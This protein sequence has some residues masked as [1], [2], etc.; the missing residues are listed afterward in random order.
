M[1]EQT[2]KLA[3]IGLTDEALELL[4]IARE[5]GLFKIA[6]VGDDRVERAEMCARGYE[7]P[8]YTD[9]RQLIVQTDADMLLFGAPVHECGDYIKLGMQEHFHILQT[10]PP[11]LNF[12]QLAAFYHLAKKENVRFFTMPHRR[13]GASFNDIREFLTEDQREANFWHLITAVCHVP[14]GELEPE[15]RW[16]YDPQTAGGG[17][18]LQSCYDMVDQLLL[19]FGMPQRVYALMMSQAPDR[20]QRMSL[21]EDTAVVTMEFTETLIA[22]LCASRTLGPAR[23]HVRIHGK[24][25]HL[26]ATD[27]EAVLYDN[28]GILLRQR[29]YPEDERPS[30]KRM[31]ENIAMGLLE[32]EGNVFYPEHGFDLYTFAVIEAA[33][34]SARTGMAEEPARILKLADIDAAG[35]I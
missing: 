20:Q 6:A 16:L 14:L 33:Y 32:P 9:F 29:N 2:I 28:N 31:L 8:A 4:A 13:F 35:L 23:R 34:L 17:V 26:T 27:E 3:A 1:T 25:Q 11:A 24:Q 15:R 12:E 22:Q 21:T 30:K 18:L 5:S 10:C 7:C 19:C